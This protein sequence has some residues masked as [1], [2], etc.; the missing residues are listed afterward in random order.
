V[1]QPPEIRDIADELSRLAAR[2][3]ARVQAALDRLTGRN[4]QSRTLH[5]EIQATVSTEMGRLRQAIAR[6]AR[7]KLPVVFARGDAEAARRVGTTGMSADLAAHRAVEQAIAR[8]MVEKALTATRN[9][10]ASTKALLRR[11]AADEV[12]G[13][14]RRKRS[15]EKVPARVTQIMRERGVHA[16]R[17]SNGARHGMDDYFEMLSRTVAAR[18]YNAA[19]LERG[20]RHGVIA[21][22]VQDGHGCQWPTGHGHAPEANGLVVSIELFQSFPIAHPRCVRVPLLRTDIRDPAE[23]MDGELPSAK[24]LDTAE[25]DYYRQVARQAV[26]EEARR[27]QLAGRRPDRLDARRR[28]IE[29][30]A[31]RLAA[32]R[33]AGDADVPGDLDIQ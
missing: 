4:P 9:V 18:M 24:I 12:L 7:E 26:Q 30:R 21:A 20:K 32:R 5:R 19:I 31:A 15:F 11:V 23:L 8:E 3:W 33:G 17:Y 13:A 2:A 25:Q 6:W 22:E 16:V 29:A 10:E 1:A 28:R 27:A 14:M